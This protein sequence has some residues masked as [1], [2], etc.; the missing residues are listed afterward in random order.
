MP[1]HPDFRDQYNSFLKEY[2]SKRGQAYFYAYMKKHK[3]DYTK[4]RPSNK[5]TP[6]KEDIE[7]L[8]PE[9]VAEILEANKQGFLIF[10]ADNPTWSMETVIPEGITRKMFYGASMPIVN[11]EMKDVDGTPQYFLEGFITTPLRDLQGETVSEDVF[12]EW[13]A[14]MVAP[15]HNLGW[16]FHDSPYSSPE[17]KAKPAIL[18]FVEAQ[19]REREFDGKKLRGLW[20]KAILNTAHPDFK[21]IWEGAK[22]GFINAFSA[23]FIPLLVDP[24]RRI[25]QRAKYLSTSLVMAPANEGAT[26]TAAY[27]KSFTGQKDMESKAMNQ[28]ASQSIEDILADLRNSNRLAAGP[29]VPPSPP[30]VAPTIISNVSA[31]PTNL[32]AASVIPPPPITTTF[33]P[34]EAYSRLDTQMQTILARLD[35]ASPVPKPPTADEVKKVLD[36]LSAAAGKPPVIKGVLFSAED[37]EDEVRRAIETARVEGR[38]G[39]VVRKGMGELGE[40]PTGGITDLSAEIIVNEHSIEGMLKRIRI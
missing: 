18:R 23:E 39:E 38:I 13:A 34:Q 4:P 26:I 15:P 21:N 8:R 5:E 28:S 35:A 30:L 6:I 33:N 7:V 9:E 20:A 40:L 37:V 31:V 29:P 14:D 3:I 16:P 19:I 2:G 17:N 10:D 1:I 12:V 24:I 32:S 22:N 11:V 27:M 25:V 36:F